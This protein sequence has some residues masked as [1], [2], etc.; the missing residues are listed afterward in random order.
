[1]LNLIFPGAIPTDFLLAFRVLRVF[2][3]FRLFRFIPNISS[4][5]KGI[6]L[7]MKASFVVTIGVAV[8]MY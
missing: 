8:L 7:A 2:K 3:V 6:R 4:I 5:L 1:M